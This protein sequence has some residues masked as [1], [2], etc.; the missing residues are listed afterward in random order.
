MGAQKIARILSETRHWATFNFRMLYIIMESVAGDGSGGSDI[1]GGFLDGGCG[2]TAG[3]GGIDGGGCEG[4][5]YGG[6]SY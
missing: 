3:W 4:G 2:V 1:G 5:G 6:G